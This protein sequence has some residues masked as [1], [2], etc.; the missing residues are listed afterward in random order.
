[1]G[2]SMERQRQFK[3]LLDLIYLFLLIFFKLCMSGFSR[4]TVLIL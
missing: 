3:L 2:M 4:A 1:M